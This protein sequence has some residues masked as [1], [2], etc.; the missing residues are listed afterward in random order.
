ML[1]LVADAHERPPWIER[2]AQHLEQRRPLLEHLEQV[3]VARDLA[4]A[5]A[6]TSR[7]AAPPTYSRCSCW[8]TSVNAGR[9]ASR[10]AR[11]RSVRSGLSKRPPKPV[12]AELEPGE[13]LVQVLRGPVREP[14]VDRLVEDGHALRDACRST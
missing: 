11:S 5:G 12:A 13:L 9:S 14:G 2:L 10:N 8:T 6:S 1:E 7:A 4:R 3:A